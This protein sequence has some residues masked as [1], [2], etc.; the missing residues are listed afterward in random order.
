MRVV[1]G[2]SYSMSFDGEAES[3]IGPPGNSSCLWQA[4]AGTKATINPPV[5]KV[6]V[7]SKYECEALTQG[8]WGLSAALHPNHRQEAGVGSELAPQT[9]VPMKGLQMS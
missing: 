2:S 4:T 6:G 9:R 1:G 5:S 7:S 8:G 3:R